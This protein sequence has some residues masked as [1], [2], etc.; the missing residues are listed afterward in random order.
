MTSGS[1]VIFCQEHGGVMINITA[2]L[3]VRG[4]SLQAHAGSA[5]AAIGESASGDPVI[6][7]V[8]SVCGA[9]CMAFP[10]E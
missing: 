4:T 6:C 8:D 10:N 9:K 3:Q 7:N 5:K 1:C 2:T